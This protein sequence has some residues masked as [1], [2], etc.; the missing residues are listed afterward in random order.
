MSSGTS[1][2][3]PAARQPV[4]FQSSD[5]KGRHEHHQESSEHTAPEPVDLDKVL[6]VK[7]AGG[8]FGD[9]FGRPHELH[10]EVSHKRG[11]VIDAQLE[12]EEKAFLDQKQA[13]KVESESKE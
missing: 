6:K 3:N 8:S 13:R 9:A 5:Q 12:A 10:G 11:A 2:S 1:V 7:Q 4:A